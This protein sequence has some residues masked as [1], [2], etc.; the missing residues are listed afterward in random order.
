[1]ISPTSSNIIALLRQ[2]SGAI[3][4]AAIYGFRRAAFRRSGPQ[5]NHDIIAYSAPATPRLEAITA[6]TYDALH[7]GL[8]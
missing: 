5:G 2:C 1:M 4:A 8:R 7:H 3:P 6:N